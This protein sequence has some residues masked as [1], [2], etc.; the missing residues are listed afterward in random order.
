MADL[1]G[2][3][4]KLNGV[5]KGTNFQISLVDGEVS[6]DGALIQDFS[7]QYARQITRVYE[8]GSANQYFIEGPTQ[9]NAAL[10]QLVGPTSVVS[11]IAEG[12][13]TLCDTS[14]RALTL[15]AGMADPCTE[16]GTASP[17]KVL[18]LGNPISTNFQIGGSAA[19]FTVSSSIGIM[20]TRLD[21]G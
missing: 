14:E 18:T 4:A 6:T 19:N 8:L 12:L 20:F 17:G 11:E 21:V 3:L 15:T 10:S 13:G 1:Y 7:V 2:S 5:F 16:G 9:G